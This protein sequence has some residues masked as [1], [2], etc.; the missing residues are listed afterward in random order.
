M[1]SATNVYM[2]VYILIRTHMVPLINPLPRVP[3]FFSIHYICGV[4]FELNC[5]KSQPNNNNNKK[6]KKKKNNNNNNMNS[7]YLLFDA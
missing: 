1:C 3:L 6:K 2:F 4:G 5:N 7:L